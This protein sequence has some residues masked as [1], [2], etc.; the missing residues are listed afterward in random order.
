MS[1]VQ[2]YWVTLWRQDCGTRDNQWKKCCC[3]EKYQGM[4]EL[5]NNENQCGEKMK[6]KKRQKKRPI[7]EPD[8]GSEY[9]YEQGWM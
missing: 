9:A 8:P 2:T 1:G 4:P 3:G 7:K 5:W 6:T